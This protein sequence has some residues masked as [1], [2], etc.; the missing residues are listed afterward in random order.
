MNYW[1]VEQLRF[2]IEQGPA[3][4]TIDEATGVLSGKPIRAGRDEV[5]ISA[6]LEHEHRPLDPA[7]LQW[8]IEKVSG[9]RVR[10]VGTAKQRFVI[11][12][13]R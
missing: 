12:A 9:S 8:G 10:S 4:L 5:V 13:T 2:R 11:H 6:T 3:W 7:Q 1:D